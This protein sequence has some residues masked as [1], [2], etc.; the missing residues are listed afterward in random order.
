MSHVQGWHC[1]GSVGYLVKHFQH[2]QVTVGIELVPC[3]VAGNGHRDPMAAQLMQ[4]G[5]PPPP[6][7]A[8]P[9]LVS[10]LYGFTLIMLQM[11][12][13]LGVVRAFMCMYL[14]CRFS[15][16]VPGM[17]VRGTMCVSQVQNYFVGSR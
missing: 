8:L 17:C 11:S 6:G 7:G 1:T 2:I 16:L 3:V 12:H 14:R 5:D 10:I 13:Q 9:P 4:E 15:L